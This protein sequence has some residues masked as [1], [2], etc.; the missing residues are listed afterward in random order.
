[1]LP[2]LRQLCGQPLVYYINAELD[3]PASGAS[4]R[5]VERKRDYCCFRAPAFSPPEPRQ[6]PQGPQQGSGPGGGLLP[7]PCTQSRVKNHP[8]CSSPA[9]SQPGCTN[10]RREQRAAVSPVE[11]SSEESENWQHP[12]FGTEPVLPTSPLSGAGGGGR[13]DSRPPALL[14]S[15]R[16]TSSSLMTTA[17]P[18]QRATSTARGVLT[19]QLLRLLPKLLG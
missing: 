1:M 13:G 12:L 15:S 9:S 5:G 2:N 11:E 7:L 17:A 8:N 3:F 4:R 18:S 19:Q 10:T 6:G 16:M 14:L